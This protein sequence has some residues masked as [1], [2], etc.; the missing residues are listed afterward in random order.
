MR[1][2]VE[3]E[4]LDRRADEGWDVEED[5]LKDIAPPEHTYCQTGSY[6]ERDC[7]WRREES[8]DGTCDGARHIKRKTIV[9]ER[10]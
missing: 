3:G 7:V 1:G 10:S 2:C 5:E 4:E 6:I 8:V 9:I